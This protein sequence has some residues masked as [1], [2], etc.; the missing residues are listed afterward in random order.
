MALATEPPPSADIVIF[1]IPLRIRDI[2]SSTPITPVLHTR[3]SSGRTPTRWAAIAA[4]SCASLYP[5]SPTHALAMPAL[6]TIA[7][8]RPWAR[9][10]LFTV[11]EGD[12]IALVVKTPAAT[13]WASERIPA[14]SSLSSAKVFSPANVAP[15]VNP[16]VVVTV[17]PSINVI[18]PAIC[19]STEPRFLGWN[20]PN[21]NWHR[22]YH[23]G[24]PP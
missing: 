12:L 6:T 11:I 22:V 10:S 9:C 18:S 1:S 5:C 21:R 8:T 24:H 13:H 3:T 4:V 17:P 7:R 20:R 23:R 16:G 19:Y 2:G 15:P 14:R